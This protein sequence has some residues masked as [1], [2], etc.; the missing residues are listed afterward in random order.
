MQKEA[1]VEESAM[2]SPAGKKA[3][4]EGCI[5]MKKVDAYGGGR[6][7]GCAVQSSRSTHKEH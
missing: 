5:A 6:S 1:L 4:V 3:F 7:E 2:E